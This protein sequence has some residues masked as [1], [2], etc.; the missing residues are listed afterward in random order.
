M[1]VK[2]S[3]YGLKSSGAVFRAKLESLLHDIGCTPSKADLDVWMTP[4]IKS[5]VT[6]YYEYALVYVNNILVI[7]CVPM[8]KIKGIKYVFKLKEDKADPTNMYLGASLEQAET[9][10]GT[11]CWSMSAKKYVKAAVINL[12]ATLAK[13]DMQLPT[14]HYPMLTNYHPSEDVSNELNT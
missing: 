4:E 1:V 14:S 5:Y 7:M 2:M 9:K 8:K 12:E 11:K 6:E 3:L 13:R 10:G